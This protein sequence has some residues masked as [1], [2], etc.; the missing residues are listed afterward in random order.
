MLL[1]LIQLKM[2]LVLRVQKKKSLYIHQE[3]ITI[4]LFVIV[5]SRIL[6]IQF[7]LKGHQG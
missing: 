7:H 2:G 4:N 5:L 6:I 1:H 3:T